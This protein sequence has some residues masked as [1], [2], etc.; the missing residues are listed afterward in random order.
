MLELDASLRRLIMTM[1]NRVQFYTESFICAVLAS[2]ILSVGNSAVLA[3]VGADSSF[4]PL[5]LGNLW[6][7]QLHGAK[8]LDTMQVVSDTVMP[9]GRRY[10]K[11]QRSTVVPPSRSQQFE[12]VDSMGSTWL[13][14][15]HNLDGNASTSEILMESF[16]SQLNNSWISY[17]RSSV[18]DSARIIWRGKLLT[19]LIKDSLLA[20]VVEYQ[21]RYGETTWIRFASSIGILTEEFELLSQDE[22]VGAIV[23][24]RRYGTLVSVQRDG[25][26]SLP[27][28]FDLMQNYPNPFNGVTLVLYRIPSSSPVSLKVFD[29]QG[30][31]IETLCQEYQGSG[32]YSVAF[33]GSKLSS[34]IYFCRLVGLLGAKTRAMVLLK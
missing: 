24:G 6:Q 3:Q 11:V 5:A 18:G 33:D 21:F 30:R 19:S 15:D 10:F 34:G 17:R 14:D 25:Q 12:R 7:F 8:L 2:I 22:L 27:V 26:S 29:I 4:Y 16:S 32:Q 1:L 13:Y 28:G 9:N 20:V 23:S 31:E